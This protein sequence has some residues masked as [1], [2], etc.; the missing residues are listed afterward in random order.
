MEGVEAAD[1]LGSGVVTN[2]NKSEAPGVSL[3]RLS[4]SVGSMPAATDRQTPK[5]PVEA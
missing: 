1:G 2:E 4:D 3:K 5:N